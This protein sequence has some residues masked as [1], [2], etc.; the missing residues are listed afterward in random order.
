MYAS[1]AVTATCNGL[2][3]E[4]LNMVECFSNICA[5]SVHTLATWRYIHAQ[6]TVLPMAFLMAS[7]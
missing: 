5:I 6:S 7:V 4:M 2:S 3:Y 1:T